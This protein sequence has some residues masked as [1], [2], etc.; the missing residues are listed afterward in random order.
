[1]VR[2][3]HV[4]T[5][6]SLGRHIEGQGGISRSAR[7]RPP[8]REDVR[9]AQGHGRRYRSEV[10]GHPVYLAVDPDMEHRPLFWPVP[11]DPG[12]GKRVGYAHRVSSEPEV[13]A[14]VEGKV[15]VIVIAAPDLHQVWEV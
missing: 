2:H 5:P 7:Q 13:R 1:M 10:K 6:R 4:V 8:V 3:Q 9:V 15:D 11:D 12:S 14:V